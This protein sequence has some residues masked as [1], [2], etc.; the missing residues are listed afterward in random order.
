MTKVES[1]LTKVGFIVEEQIIEVLTCAMMF[2]NDPK[3]VNTNKP[4]FE[5]T[6]IPGNCDNLLLIDQ[7]HN[8]VTI[9]SCSSLQNPEFDIAKWY[10]SRLFQVNIDTNVFA[11]RILLQIGLESEMDALSSKRTWLQ[12]MC[13]ALVTPDVL[14]CWKRKERFSGK[15][16]NDRKRG[17]N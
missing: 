14:I 15:G 1:C 11:V 9:L 5:V 2:F 10:K 16:G 8:L 3:L 7:G 17:W 4:R 12:H 13:C 6:P